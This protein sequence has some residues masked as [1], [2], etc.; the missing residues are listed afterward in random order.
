MKLGKVF[1][2]LLLICIFLCA[3]FGCVNKIEKE[4][5]P[6]KEY[7]GNRVTEKEYEG[8]FADLSSVYK[9]VSPSVV[10]VVCET[11][12]NVGS[13][14]LVDS[15]NGYV[16][17]SSSL[18]GNSIS[19]KDF[20]V[21]LYD[22]TKLEVQAIYCDT[23]KEGIFQQTE[24]AN[25]DILILNVNSENSVKLPEPVSFAGANSLDFGDR[26]F[27]VSS[28]SDN[29]DT[30]PGVMM[31]NIITNPRNTHASAFEL[32]SGDW[33]F[34]GSFE[35]LIQTGITVNGG[36]AGAP[37]FNDQGEV[38]G[39][40]NLRTEETTVFAN[41][42]AFGISFA[43]PSETVFAFLQECGISY[44]LHSSSEIVFES[45]I[46]NTSS[47]TQADDNVARALMS[48]ENGQ[49]SD[50]FVA[51]DSCEVIFK[52]E[53]KS[54]DQITEKRIYDNNLNKIVKIVVVYQIRSLTGQL[55]SAVSEGSGF[56]IG[57]DGYVLTNLHVINKLSSQNQN[58]GQSANATVD[59]SDISVYAAFEQGTL[60]EKNFFE[61]T[62]KFV[63]LPMQVVAY[64]KTGD[65][66][67]LRFSNPVY[68]TDENGNK[69][70]GFES[71]C[72]FET[73]LPTNGSHVVAVG[74]A[75]GYGI[76]VS[77]GI[78]SDAEFS[79]YESLYGYKMIQ[80]DC[81]INSG[82]SGG[83]LFDEYG[84]VVGINTLGLDT[85]SMQ[86]FE[87]VSWAIP[88]EF[89]IQFISDLNSHDMSQKDIFYISPFTQ[90]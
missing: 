89:A 85:T 79:A 35:Y 1:S 3:S 73:K 20:Q 58:N 65:L 76:S 6:E 17:T 14:F 60:T 69:S 86:D 67:V 2:F 49:P 43:T 31:Q 36:N 29:E 7:T 24:P 47:L 50:Y 63:L 33:F 62:T 41:S 48:S 77:T 10:T 15:Q 68:Y 75:L 81:P 25:S 78:V 34:D 87:N 83:P 18:L 26:C 64:H 84:N 13:G 21:L 32:P 42:D 5:I 38:V 19:Q 57:P 53:S 8:D 12:G 51:D 90:I 40:M 56:I 46:A 16:V 59:I 66:A 4:E 45:I 61:E 72:N 55:S 9:A 30:L 71:V 82:N 44:N 80:T 54:T 37:L 22:G 52:K 27:T 88:A 39:I 11:N 70:S 74:N 23:I 28:V